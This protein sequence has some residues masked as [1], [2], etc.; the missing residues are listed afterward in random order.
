MTEQAQ[1][2]IS[3]A[4]TRIHY[5]NNYLRII[6]RLHGLDDRKLLDS[7]MHLAATPYTGGVDQG[8]ALTTTLERNINGVTGG[9][10]H[11]EHH[12]TLFARHAV[13]QGRLAHIRATNNGHTNALLFRAW[14]V[15]W[16][17]R[18]G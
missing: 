1:V 18:E 9:A 11:V 4:F 15:L 3:D 6:N 17:I 13:N 12:H 8:I 10:G 16:R 14:V 7:F 2:L 5:Q